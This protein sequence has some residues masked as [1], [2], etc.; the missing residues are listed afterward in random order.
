MRWTVYGNFIGGYFHMCLKVQVVHCI[1]MHM[2]NPVI[3]VEKHDFL[4]E[5]ADYLPNEDFR[6]YH[7]D[8]KVAGMK[9]K[10]STVT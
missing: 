4:L 10:N 8:I 5:K 9:G 1:Q 2:R 3:G 7:C 6:T